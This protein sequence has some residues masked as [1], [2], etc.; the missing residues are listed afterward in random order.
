MI[1]VLGAAMRLIPGSTVSY[2]QFSG[3]TVN[4]MGVKIPQYSEAVTVT[5]HIQPL[6]SRLYAR[7]GLTL[8]KEYKLLHIP[9]NVMGVNRKNTGDYVT[10]NGRDYSIVGVADWF[11]YGNQKWVRLILTERK[12]D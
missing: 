1:N 4:A 7:F 11:D 3:S 5:G 2:A 10:W 9:A 12:G 8:E 6:P